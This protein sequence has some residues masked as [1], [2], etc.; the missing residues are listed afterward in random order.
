MLESLALS[1]A[2]LLQNQTHIHVTSTR[3]CGVFFFLFVCLVKLGQCSRCHIR[4][5][6]SVVVI[7]EIRIARKKQYLTHFLAKKNV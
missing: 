7:G 5:R 6:K 3:G 2:F 1:L 4:R